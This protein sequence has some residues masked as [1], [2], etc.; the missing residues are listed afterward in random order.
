MV[1]PSSGELEP[2]L[3]TYLVFV[4]NMTQFLLLQ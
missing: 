4:Q 2:G 3:L 1:Y